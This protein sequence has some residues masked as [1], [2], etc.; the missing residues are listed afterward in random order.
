MGNVDQ[1]AD[2][3]PFDTDGLNEKARK[4]GLKLACAR[5]LFF[6]HF[7]TLTFSHG[8]PPRKEAQ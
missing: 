2:L 4:A 8:E 7:G 1:S 6:H 5:D 3:G